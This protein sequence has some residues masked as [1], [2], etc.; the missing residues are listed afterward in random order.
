MSP[1]CPPIYRY[2]YRISKSDEDEKLN[3]SK[4]VKISLTITKF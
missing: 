1:V 3:C 2:Y 4:L